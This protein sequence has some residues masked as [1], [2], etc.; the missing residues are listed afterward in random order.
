MVCTEKHNNT[1]IVVLNCQNI[2]H[3]YNKYDA[4]NDTAEIIVYLKHSVPTNQQ[5]LVWRSQCPILNMLMLILNMLVQQSQH[6]GGE[7]TCAAARHLLQFDGQ[8]VGEVLEVQRRSGWRGWLAW[9][10]GDDGDIDGRIM[11]GRRRTTRLGW[12]SGRRRRGSAGRR[13]RRRRRCGG[14]VRC[15]LR[16]RLRSPDSLRSSWS[17]VGCRLDDRLRGVRRD[18]IFA[19]YRHD[20]D[21]AFD[22]RT[23]GIGRGTGG[24]WL[25][26]GGRPIVAEERQQ[27]HHGPGIGNGLGCAV[28]DALQFVAVLVRNVGPHGLDFFG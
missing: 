10:S 27:W 23:S 8:V 1:N 4:V 7:S 18:A 13:N 26:A 15:E 22:R 2:K 19:L 21:A 5:C 25:A 20:S 16:R 17:V 24:R 28:L 6:F 9:L 3:R 11:T 12:N 14:V